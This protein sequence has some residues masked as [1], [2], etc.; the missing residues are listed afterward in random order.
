[1]G[2][3]KIQKEDIRRGVVIRMNILMSDGA[4]SMATIIALHYNKGH[5]PDSGISSV[6]VVRPMCWAHE[7]FDSRVGLLSGESFNMSVDSLL[8]PTSDVEVFQG[9]DSIR[10]LLT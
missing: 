7:H 5:L 4:Y 2:W 10:D 3:R 8:S 6:S 1:M 9:R